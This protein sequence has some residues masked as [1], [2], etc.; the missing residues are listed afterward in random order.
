MI[1]VA[2]SVVKSRQW[3]AES[4]YLG[5]FCPVVAEEERKLMRESEVACTDSFNLHK[6]FRIVFWFPETIPTG[7]ER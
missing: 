7:F 1:P 2:P 5:R 3:I 6:N 4:C